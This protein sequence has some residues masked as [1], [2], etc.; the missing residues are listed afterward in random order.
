LRETSRMRAVSSPACAERAT[1]RTGR[2]T[3]KGPGCLRDAR[4]G[5]TRGVAK[6]PPQ[7]VYCAHAARLPRRALYDWLRALSVV[8]ILG[9][10]FPAW[11]ISIA[12]GLVL[13]L[14]V[15]RGL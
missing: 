4:G 1:S 10:F 14:V 15:W 2:F 11:L 7:A 5:R 6:P 9:S 12:T 8:N 3:T 13:A